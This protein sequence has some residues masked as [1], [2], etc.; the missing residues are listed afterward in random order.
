EP[1]AGLDPEGAAA[2][3]QLFTN[4]HQQGLTIV[5]VTHDMELVYQYATDVIVMEAGQVKVQTTPF[6]LFFGKLQ[7]NHF[8][9][10]ALITFLKACQ[11]QGQ[12]L[13]I[14]KIRCLADYQPYREGK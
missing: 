10:P 6:D 5:M 8:R 3:M 4:L 12:T 13:P 2:M 11:Q 1:T 14:E 7:L 9:E